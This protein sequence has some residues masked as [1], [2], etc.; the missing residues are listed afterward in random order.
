MI[1]EKER[2]LWMIDWK[3]QEFKLSRK[4]VTLDILFILCVAR[5]SNIKKSEF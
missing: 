3:E 1:D 4:L 2:Y 5:W